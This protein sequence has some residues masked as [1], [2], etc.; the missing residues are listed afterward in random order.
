MFSRG[1][2][3]SMDL[4]SVIEHFKKLDAQPGKAVNQVPIRLQGASGEIA[5]SVYENNPAKTFSTVASELKTVLAAVEGAGIVVSRFF[6]A[7]NYTPEECRAVLFCLL[8][9]TLSKTKYDA[10]KDNTI[11]KVIVAK[12][13]NVGA[14]T[15]AAKAIKAAKL[16]KE[17]R[18]VLARLADDSRL[19]LLDKVVEKMDMV[20]A[21]DNKQVDVEVTSAV[22]LSKAQESALKKVMPAFVAKDE[23]AN[24]SFLVDPNVIGGLSVRVGSSVVDLTAQSRLVSALGALN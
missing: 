23:K 16:S 22:G 4:D 14:F 24:F 15:D 18:S 10:I 8:T 19:D 5:A 11:S 13:E 7:N 20:L 17:T 21:A 12:A 2:A 6:A 9:D 1:M 3:T